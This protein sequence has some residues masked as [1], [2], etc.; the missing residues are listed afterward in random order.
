MSS[1][2]ERTSLHGEH[3]AR[4]AKMV[5]FAGFEMPVQYPT[6]ITAEHL[7]VRRKAGL[8]DVSHMGEF[9]VR[10]PEALDFVQWLS[11]NDAARVEVGQAQY[12]VM[13][14][15]TGGVIDERFSPDR[16]REE[17]R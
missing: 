12:S 1:D 6:G 8:F 11:V 4:D 5:P 17:V 2:L 13:C 10:G 9:V 14:R 15:P 3:V 16:D 7:A